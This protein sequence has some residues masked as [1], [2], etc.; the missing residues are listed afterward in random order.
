MNLSGL[1]P[2]L[3][4]GECYQQWLDELKSALTG[5]RSA[6][7]LLRAAHPYLLAA[8][9]QDLGAPLLIVTGRPD[10]AAAMFELLRA[11]LGDL[12]A[13]TRL[14]RF[15]EPPTLLYERAPWPREVVSERLAVL[16]SLAS[17]QSPIIVASVRALMQRTCPP[18]SFRANTRVLKRHQLS[19]LSATVLHWINVGYER[20]SVVQSAGEFSSRGG[21]VDVFPPASPYPVR[22]ELFGDEIESLRR[23]DP[24]SQRSQE[25]IE[26]VVITPAHEAMARFGPQAAAR[27]Q[28][29]DMSALPEDTAAT[30]AQDLS[31]LISGEPFAGIEFYLPYFYDETASLLDYLPPGG[32]LVVLDEPVEI[33]D[34]WHELEEQ[35]VDLHDRARL[36]QSLPPGYALPYLVWDDWRDALGRHTTLALG[37]R[38]MP[39]DTVEVEPQPLSE[40][41]TP[42]PHFGGQIKP[43]IDHVAQCQLAGEHIVIAS[44]QAERLAH[45]WRE[46]DAA[47][48]ARPVA[49]LIEPPQGVVF[50]QGTITDGFTYQIASSKCQIANS[51]RQSPES[52]DRG[53]QIANLATLHLL[54][55]GEIFGWVRPAP[56]RRA[57]PRAIAPESYLADLRPGDYVVHVEHGVGIFQGLTTLKMEGVEREYLQ[58]V[59]AA[60]DK[61][62]VPIHQAD[63]LS[64]YI[65]ADERQPTVH[66]L[67]TAEWG[68]VRQRAQAAA[69]EVAKELLELYAVREA[70]SGFAF[71]ADTAWQ[72]ELEAA[73]PYIETEDQLRA[74]HDVKADMQKKRPMDRLIC[75]DVGYGK[76]EVALRAAFKAVQDGKQVAVLVPTTILAQQHLN[77]FSARLAAYP[78]NV[79]MLSRFRSRAEQRQILDKLETGQVDIVIGTHRLIQKDVRFQDLGLLVIDEEQR[80][81]VTHKERLKQMRTEV[82]VLTMTAT[83]IPRTLYLSLTGVRDI[84]TIDTP[85][86]ERLP[87]F[88]YVGKYD[89]KLVR[90]AILRELDRGGQVYFVHNRVQGIEQIRRRLAAVVP[91]ASIAVAHGQ[92][93][94]DKLE[95]VMIDFVVGKIDV[96]LST[97]IIESGL[98]I[99]N[100]NTLVVNHAD[101]FGLA[102]LYQLRGRVGR[103]ATRA[104]A[105]FLYDRDSALS[106]ESRQ[107]LETIRQ[108]NELGAG[109]SIAMRDLEIRGAGDILGTRQS[110]HIAAVG[111][112]LYTRMLAHAVEELRASHQGLAPPPLPTQSVT[113]DLPLAA[114]LPTD[115]VP[116]ET[117]RLQLYR[118]MAKL[119]TA[120]DIT[121]IEQELSDRFG[122]LPAPA[123]DLVFQLQL[124]VLAQKARV[125]AVSLSGG[126]FAIKVD[127]LEMAHRSRLQ[128]VLGDLAFVSNRQINVPRHREQDWRRVLVTVLEKL[129][130]A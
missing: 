65:G 88:T 26:S 103:S 77:T 112:D 85:P 61:L 14:L 16:A 78:V 128:R 76:T 89:D 40:A 97:V 15:S 24:A 114:Y 67:G 64:R 43:F 109:Y 19:K 124:K 37:E 18:R 49:E 66:R 31:A 100:A 99:P 39:Q 101:W 106:E 94:E 47:D 90:T 54:T 116:D 5:E 87:V 13:G 53:L 4:E 38:G 80:F 52:S 83:P 73:F 129:A 71:S 12:A 117:L 95:R 60:D 33:E 51:K 122:P 98:D 70:V 63:R 75:G 36:D 59:Y 125:A 55:D 69:L 41:F 123:A 27:L 50:V 105:Y 91:E 104:Y 58:I 110:G 45:L 1:L 130:G 3:R 82:D 113:I 102:Q 72:Q 120:K 126:Q 84:S 81:G 10:R 44:R 118:R 8:L 22:I 111:F 79:E 74:L 119:D 29:W 20:A 21:I 57:R 96:L 56:R 127:W 68:H 46:R 28:D 11:Y 2:L 6:L 92:M 9:A 62:Y 48:Y 32:G 23:F 25:T 108:A 7:P 35:A 30:F 17:I 86:E 121:R 34:A 42:G 107:R 115:Y 93:A